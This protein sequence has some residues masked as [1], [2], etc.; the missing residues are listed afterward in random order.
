MRGR[1]VHGQEQEQGQAQ[2]QSPAQTRTPEEIRDIAA[3]LAPAEDSQVLARAAEQIDSSGDGNPGLDRGALAADGRSRSPRNVTS[4]GGLVYD[5]ERQRVLLVQMK[6][7]PTEGRWMLPGG[8]MDP[9]ETLDVAVVREVREETG[10]A[11]EPVGIVGVRSRRIGNDNDT[12]V[13]WLLRPAVSDVGSG[14]EAVAH[15]LEPS[16]DA[17]EIAVARWLPIDELLAD[18]SES[19]AYLVRYL[20]GKLAEGQLH[21]LEY[22]DDYAQ[23]M[24]GVTHSDWKL[25]R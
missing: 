19:A 22:A 20:V 21:P 23:L 16:P 8:L 5:A 1:V 2:A 13:I 4:V 3:S 6:Y 9:G 15:M 7:G 12:Y 11:A 17:R 18:E 14:G 24:S 25:Y 10:I